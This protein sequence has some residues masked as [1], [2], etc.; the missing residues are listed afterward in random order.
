M[1]GRLFLL[2]SSLK[3]LGQFAKTLLLQGD[4]PE[5]LFLLGKNLSF[6][7]Y[8]AAAIG[9]LFESVIII[10]AMAS[11]VHEK[12]KAAKNKIEEM[13]KGMQELSG[14]KTKVRSLKKPYM[15]FVRQLRC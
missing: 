15:I 12:T 13:T 8:N 6:I 11:F 2:A 7:T 5:D 1:R 3:I 10:L 4:L 9:S 14:K